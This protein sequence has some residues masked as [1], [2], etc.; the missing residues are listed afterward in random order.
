MLSARVP[1]C[2]PFMDKMLGVYKKLKKK[3]ETEELETVISPR[4]LENWA[5]IARYDG[6]NLAA[7]KTI[8]P[9]AKNDK[10]LEGAIRGIIYLY[11]WT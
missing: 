4:N 5:R 6:Y 3:I 7:E 11:R 1:E 8:L 9:V 2:V 10:T